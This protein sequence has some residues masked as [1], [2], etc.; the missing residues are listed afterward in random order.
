MS[1]T[2]SMNCGS[3]DSLNASVWCGFS[4]NARQIRL[5]ARLAHPGRGRH[6][7]RRPVRRV[8]RLLLER[9]HDHPL[10]VLVADRARLARP[11]LVMQPIEA[12]PRE[13]AAPLADRRSRCSQARPRSRCSTAPPPPPTRSGNATPAPASSSAAEPTAR[14]PPAPPQSA[15]PPHAAP[16]PPPIVVDDHDDFATQQPGPCELTTQVTSVRAVKLPFAVIDCDAGKAW[17][18]KDER[19][20]IRYAAVVH[21][22]RGNV[23]EFV[24]AGKQILVLPPSEPRARPSSTGDE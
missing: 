11:R 1:R 7:A 18:F 20:A 8:R 12:A 3:G 19:V 21:A 24:R 6:R 15:R 16:S 13:P 22:A 17:R 4:P 9:L 23:V 10:D 14:A 2:L 5:T